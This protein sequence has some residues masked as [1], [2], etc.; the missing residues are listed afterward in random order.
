MISQKECMN[1]RLGSSRVCKMWLIN[2]FP[3]Q[4]YKIMFL[5]TVYSQLNWTCQDPVIQ[6]IKS[7]VER[8]THSTNFLSFIG[9]HALIIQEELPSPPG[10][11]VEEQDYHVM[12]LALNLVNTF[13]YMVNTY[14]IVPT[15]DDYAISLGASATL[16][17]V[18]VGC[19]PI[20]QL[21]SSVFLSAWS[22]TS[23]FRPLIFS[24]IAL[25]LGNI[26]YATAYD[27]DSIYILLL[28]RL[29]CGYVI[30]IYIVMWQLFPFSNCY[31]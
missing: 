9:Q 20:S 15:A 3:Q 7:A 5:L 8:L 16:C 23:Y 17:G 30:W 6:L 11:H 27:I 19:M 12:S 21:V 4:P 1:Q 28:G 29:L 26:L 14:I 13:L 2:F 10:E 18:I 25:F 24:S 22:N 31:L